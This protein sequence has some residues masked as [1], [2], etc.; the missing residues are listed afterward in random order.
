VNDR[1]VPRTRAARFRTTGWI[2]L[3]SGLTGAGAFYWFASRAADQ[4][5]DDT[6]ALG[7][8]RSMQH[9]MGVMMGTFGNMLTEWQTALATPLGEALIIAVVT[10]LFAGYFFRVAWVA[11][12]DDG[13]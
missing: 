13:D 4:A 9:G 2:V 6:N 3:A 12:H 8:A 5:L 7:Y 11:E 1:P 10:A